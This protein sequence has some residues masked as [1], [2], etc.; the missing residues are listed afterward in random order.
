MN[1]YYIYSPKFDVIS[2]PMTFRDAQAKQSNER[3]V[4]DNKVQILK[5]VVDEDGEVVP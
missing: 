5:I 2:R 3:E 1:K 4:Y